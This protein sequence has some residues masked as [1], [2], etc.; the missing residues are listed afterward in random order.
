MSP[1]LLK[2]LERWLVNTLA[3]LVAVEVL[4]GVSYDKPRDLFV[5][6]LLL[7][8]LNAFLKPILM[9]IALPLVISTLGLFIVVINAA[10]LM[11]ISSLV[12]GFHV[13]GFWWA[14]AGAIIISLVSLAVSHLTGR[15]QSKLEMRWNRPSRPR[16]P[17]KRPPNSGDGPVIDV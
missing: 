7:G 6:S 3:V 5:A 16:D 4:P 14:V 12:P 17:T 11:L 10:L 13:G 15:N 9:L 2:F 1:G 8:I